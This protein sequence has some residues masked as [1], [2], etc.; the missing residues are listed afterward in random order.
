MTGPASG[1][2]HHHLGA[3]KVVKAEVPKTSCDMNV[4]PL[5]DVTRR[6]LVEPLLTGER[7]WG[8]GC[9]SCAVGTCRGGQGFENPQAGSLRK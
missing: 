7:L 6:A 5:I 8:V 3:D 2:H 4:T 1:H 9:A